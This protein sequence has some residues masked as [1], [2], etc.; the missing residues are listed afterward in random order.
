MSE[1]FSKANSIAALGRRAESLQRKH[2]FNP[3]QAAVAYGDFRPT[4]DRIQWIE[5]GSFFRR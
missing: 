1:R 2:G 3:K 5:D 4:L